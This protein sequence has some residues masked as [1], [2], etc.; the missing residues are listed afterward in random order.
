MNKIVVKAESVGKEYLI[1]H[2]NTKD[3]TNQRT[4]NNFKEAVTG[5]FKDTFFSQNKIDIENFW[6]IKDLNFEIREGDR[7]GFIGKNGAGKST[8]LKILSRITVPST[9]KITMYGRVASILE[10]GTGFHPDLN[11]RENIFLN[12]AILGM[13]YGEIKKHFDEIVAFSGIEKFI[14]TPVK[15]Y[16][17]GMRVRLAFSIAAHLRADILILDEVLAVGDKDFTKQ[18][19]DKMED[20]TLKEGRTILFVSH[21]LDQVKKLCNRSILLK[22]GSIIMDSDTKSVLKKYQSI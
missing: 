11:G 19:L 17:V 16:S 14:D 4:N 8:L 21:L 9:G 18:C 1:A 2:A 13:S 12:G 22:S 15:R 10:V 7:V 5:F 3:L 20:I 6:A